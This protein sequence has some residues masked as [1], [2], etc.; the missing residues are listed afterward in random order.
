MPKNC[1]NILIYLQKCLPT[2]D[3]AQIV[4]R[5]YFLFNLTFNHFTSIHQ[6]V[7]AH[8]QPQK[9]PNRDKD[10]NIKKKI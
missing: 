9:N 6:M 5:V 3:E 10:Y 2:H 4:I 8:L 1:E 7:L